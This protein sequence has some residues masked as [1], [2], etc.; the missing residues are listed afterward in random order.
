MPYKDA[1]EAKVAAR[2]RKRKQRQGVT[3]DEGVTQKGVTLEGVTGQGVTR[4]E[5]LTQEQRLQ[6]RGED[7]TN[8]LEYHNIGTK[9]GQHPF[10]GMRSVVFTPLKR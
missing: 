7:L 3:N 1:E 4:F 9:P 2:D 6:L 8:F 10:Y 5:G